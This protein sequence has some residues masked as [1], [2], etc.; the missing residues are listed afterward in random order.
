MGKTGGT[1]STR[2]PLRIEPVARCPAPR[3]S[4][5]RVGLEYV[6]EPPRPMRVRTRREPQSTPELA[7]EM[8]LI[9]EAD[10]RRH[11][12]R[13]D[14]L[15]QKLPRFRES[16]MILVR[17]RRNP[18]VVHEDARQ[19]IDTDP[20]CIRQFVERNAL[21]EPCVQELARTPNGRTFGSSTGP[22]RSVDAVFDDEPHALRE[23]RLPL[24]HCGVSF[25]AL[26]QPRQ[27][28]EERGT[29]NQ[30]CLEL[31]PASSEIE[32]ACSALEG[33]GCDVKLAHC[34]GNWNANVSKDAVRLHH[35][36]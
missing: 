26:V 18:D 13:G 23:S 8:A 25:E 22:G 24:E 19:M 9:A 17:V 7:R 5:D 15:D 10:F 2:E 4:S 12:A 27:A 28:A 20:G 11:R 33:H 3:S 16:Q 32:L 35:R 31:W 36:D 29:R 21:G 6:S 34:L 1:L 30:H 14:A